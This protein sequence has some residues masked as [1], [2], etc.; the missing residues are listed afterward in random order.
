MKRLYTLASTTIFLVGIAVF[1]FTCK[2]EYSYEGGIVSGTSS[3]TAVYTLSGAGGA[4]TGA[5]LSGQYYAGTALGPGNTVTLEADVTT[6]GTYMVSTAT[7]NGIKFS[8]SGT[9]TVTGIQNMLLQG[10]GTPSSVGS[11]SFK[12]PVGAG[13]SF[14]IDVAATPVAMA[15]FTL[16]GAPNDCQNA[17]AAGTYQDGVAMDAANTVNIMVNVTA[18]GVYTLS[19]DTLDGISFSKS[20]TFTTTGLQA[21]TLAGHG[22]PLL[23]RN[24]VFTPANGASHCS[25]NVTVLNAQPLA[26][27]VLE[28]GTVAGIN[29]C[30]YTVAGTSTAGMALNNTNTVQMR[31]YCTVLGHFTIATNIV[32]G[33]QFAFSG[34]FTMSGSQMVTL[35]GIGTPVTVG[36]HT[37]TPEIVGPHPLGGETCAFAITVL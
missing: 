16:A 13:C 28:S 18:V 24:L 21:I 34:A 19:T 7:V 35:V 33:M 37:F 10:S 15:T 9:F 17:I 29:T 32:N 4:C 36:T 14:T 2:K 26:T 30:I 23:A 6:I 1:F 31:V 3:G 22:T 20:G 11:F 25:F 12:P 5:L 8:G 27:Y